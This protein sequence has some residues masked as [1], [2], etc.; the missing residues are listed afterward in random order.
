MRTK[1]LIIDNRRELSTKYRKILEDKT[2]QVEIIKNIPIAL[3]YIQA[4]EPDIIIISDSINEDYCKLCEKIRILTYNMRPIIVA[5][6]KSAESSDKIKVLEC[7]ADDFISEPV[8]SEEFKIRIKAHIRREYETNLDTKT[9]LPTI[10]YTQKAMKRTLA[11]N[12]PWACLLTGIE[13]FYS[14]KEAYTELA[15]DRL[16]QTFG[17]I[18]NSALSE[19]DYIGMI[20]DRDFLVIT[21]PIKAEKI[22][23]FITF[24]FESV[25]NKFYS[26]QDL[27]RGYMMIRGNE[28]TEKRCE[29]IYA[30]TSGITNST[31]RFNSETEMLQE[32][33]Q[34]YH[35]T[36]NKKVSS[37]LIERPQISGK[38]SVVEEEFNNKIVII[39]PDNALSLLLS[40]TLELKGYSTQKYQTIEEIENYNPALIILDTGKEDT[41]SSKLQL[42]K[43][44]KNKISGVKI[45]TTSNFHDKEEIMNAGTDIY[46][47]KPYSI[48]ILTKWVESAIKEFNY[49]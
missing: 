35:L 47:P 28:F 38:N 45:I 34:V 48:D 26:A 2:N 15:S 27:E 19:N 20:S 8:N 10:K 39:E 14:Y 46:L 17:A 33:K 36:K 42:C 21:S 30:I 7:G 40:T 1:T 16:L 24:A 23:S 6:S 31:K 3:K 4:N 11:T 18:I 22:A 49:K 32:L 43:L 9:K 25:K 13:N 12:L 29:F 37:Y 5:M 44:L 41:N